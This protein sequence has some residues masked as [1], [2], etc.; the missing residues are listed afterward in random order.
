MA[1]SWDVDQFR[2]KGTS[3][4]NNPRAQR[5]GLSHTGQ[6]EFRVNT[7]KSFNHSVDGLQ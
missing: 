4:R 6:L 1:L 3:D 7:A 2:S 5:F